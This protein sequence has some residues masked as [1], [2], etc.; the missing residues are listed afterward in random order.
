MQLL[1]TQDI[2]FCSFFVKKSILIQ[3]DWKTSLDYKSEDFR[4]EHFEIE[5]NQQQDDT[6]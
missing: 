1:S 3:I 6:L 4:S 2:F 5:E